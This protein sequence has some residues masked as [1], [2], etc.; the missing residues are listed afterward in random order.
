MTGASAGVGRAIVRRFAQDGA[1]IGLLARDRG[2]LQATERE[3]RQA[4]SRALIQVCDVGGAEQVEAAT[5]AVEAEFGPIDI[6]INNAMVTVF[7]PVAE[8]EAADYHRV[9]EVTYLG[10]VHGTLSAL[11]R[12]RPRDHGVIVQ[13]GSALAYRGIPL[14][15]AHCAA[16][17]AIQGFQDSLSA[18]LLHEQSRVHTTMVQL[19]A[20]NTPQFDWLKTRLR[21]RA[22]PVPP[23]HQPEV[24][25]EAVHQAVYGKR[26]REHFVSPTAAATI[27]GNKIFPQLGDRYLAEHGFDSQQ[28]DELEDP[29]RPNNL[30]ETV[31]GDW[32]AHGRF[33]AEAE[34]AKQQQRQRKDLML[35]GI[36]SAAV[37][38]GAGLAKRMR[39][40]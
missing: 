10:V 16:K 24:A 2:R 34:Q 20:M 11:K 7:S 14:Q 23:I 18:E 4:G 26:K 39:R 9:T 1:N 30:Y 25:A 28:T 15:S 21:Y 19:P 27:V 37:A 8:M 6:W 5:E 29:T 22:Q 32:A 36:G 13:I 35:A 40:R 38:L 17:H 12:M 31:P 33:D 3:V